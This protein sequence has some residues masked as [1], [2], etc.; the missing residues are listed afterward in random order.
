MMTR[1]EAAY[2]ELFRFIM[3]LVPN[4]NP[5]RIHCDFEKA[6]MNAARAV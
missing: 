2:L 5:S 6:Q 1:T 3:S 4:L